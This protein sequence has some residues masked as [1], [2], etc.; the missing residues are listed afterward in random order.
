MET[1][2]E[3]GLTLSVLSRDAESTPDR[4]AKKQGVSKWVKIGVPVA[5]IVLAGAGIG[6]YFGVRNKSNASANGNQQGSGNGNG[7]GNNNGGTSI[8]LEDSRLAISTDTWMQPV[9]PSTVRNS[10]RLISLALTNN[11][12][13][14]QHR[15]PYTAHI[16]C[17][18]QED[19][20]SR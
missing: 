4:Y 20:A 17:P 19:M 10:P 1:I 7:N 3:L 9:Y 5:L 6:A 18:G 8:N 12:L 2:F 13:P 15:G 14:D 11:W 16:R